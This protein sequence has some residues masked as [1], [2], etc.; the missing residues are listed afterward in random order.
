MCVYVYIERNVCICTVLVYKHFFFFYICPLTMLRGNDVPVVMTT[1]SIQI[2]NIFN[3]K[4]QDLFGDVFDFSSW[5]GKQ[6]T[7]KMTLEHPV[8]PE[9]INILKRI[10][11][12]LNNIGTN[13]KKLLMAKAGTI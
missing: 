4:K 5:A 13:L 1:P 2:L 9:S 7:Y 10:D 12:Y 11:T 8:V 3:E 6:K